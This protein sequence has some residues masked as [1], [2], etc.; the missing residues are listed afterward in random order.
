M[1]TTATTQITYRK[2]RQGAW[3]AFGPADAVK[4]GE[5][6]N[7]AKKNGAISRR[8]VESTGKVF[9]VDGERMVYGYLA[10]GEVP[11]TTT[12]AQVEYAQAAHQAAQAATEAPA[13]KA[14]AAR[15]YTRQAQS[16]TRHDGRCTTC[17]GTLTDYDR[18]VAAIP[19]VHA[20]CI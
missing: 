19:G 16:W 20:D 13:R 3:V 14:P 6:V 7:I 1:T 12:A 9:I 10:E 15:T 4:A 17:G 2:T 11:V 5:V 18:E 8:L